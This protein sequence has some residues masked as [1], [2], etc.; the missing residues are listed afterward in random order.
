MAVET[1]TPQEGRK[2]RSPYNVIGI[3]F[4]FYRDLWRKFWQ[5]KRNDLRKE[6]EASRDVI[7]K[8]GL[9]FKVMKFKSEKPEERKAELERFTEGLGKNESKLKIAQQMALDLPADRYPGTERM[10]IQRF[11]GAISKVES[12]GRHAVL[13]QEI[14][15]EKSPHYGDRALGRYQIM[16]LRWLEWSA[17]IFEGKGVEPTPQAQEYVAFKMFMEYYD[18]L[19]KEYPDDD[20]K[21]FYA[22]S[23]RWYGGGFAVKFLGESIPLGGPDTKQYCAKVLGQMGL[24]QP[25]KSKLKSG[26]ADLAFRGKRAYQKLKKN[27]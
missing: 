27:W 14:K 21:R 16:P 22:M 25:L 6:V 20:Y 23:S 1:P 19:K 15:N 13:G 4:D 2:E 7:K 12:D 24:E 11:A 10:L 17:K 9:E 18:E 5:E 26:A 3:A 8:D